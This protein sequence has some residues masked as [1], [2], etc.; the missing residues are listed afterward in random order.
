M[1]RQTLV[2]GD[3]HSHVTRLQ[4]LLLQEGLIVFDSDGT[5]ER[6]RRDEVEIVLLGDVGHFGGAPRADIAAWELA[7][8]VA[9]KILWGNHDI[10]VVN[11]GHIFGGYH[12][13]SSFAHSVVPLWRRL[14]EEGRLL[15]AY[16]SH[17]FLLTHAGLTMGIC[18][19]K[20]IPSEI[21]E[22][23]QAFANWINEASDWE[24]DV[25]TVKKVVR[26]AIGSKRGGWSPVGGILWRDIEE[27]LYTPAPRHANGFRQ[28]F[29]HSADHKKHAVRK[30]GRKTNTRD[31]SMNSDL[32]P[33]YCVDVGGRSEYDEDHCIAGLYLPEEKVVRLDLNA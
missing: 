29:G 6:L 24:T 31:L 25:E 27:G 32:Y 3:F 21:L 10:A 13:D 30:V 8:V 11:P 12:Y 23:P 15:L 28:I 14:L 22:S 16:E 17:G 26:D 19:T 5:P 7:D 20:N 18:Q 1:T 2:I 33:S 9:D 4:E